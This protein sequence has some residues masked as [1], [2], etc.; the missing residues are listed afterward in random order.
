MGNTPRQQLN[1]VPLVFIVT[2]YLV[3]LTSYSKVKIVNHD[4]F[5]Q[6]LINLDARLTGSP[7]IRELLD[8]IIDVVDSSKWPSSV[9]S[10]W[11]E[12]D[13]NVNK[14]KGPAIKRAFMDYAS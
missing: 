4:R 13:S 8:E 10:P 12:G 7:D 2:W 1:H 14:L 5:Y 9:E 3:L 6:S 11:L